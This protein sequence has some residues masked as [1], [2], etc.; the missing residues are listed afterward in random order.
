MNIAMPSF[1][2]APFH[3]AP[4]VVIDLPFPPSV[5]RLWR[6]GGDGASRVFL[7][8]SYVKWKDAADVLL[9]SSK[10]WRGKKICG[11]FSAEIAI[12]PPKGQARGDLDNRIKAVCD[13]L[14]RVE[15]IENDKHCQRLLIEWVDI[16]RA[17]TGCRVVV[18]ACA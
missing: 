15:I 2:D 10:G 5:N 3:V 4:D 11:A 1:S 18:R 16:S 8:K 13:F 9:L 17:P 12:S 14:Q 7:S 6:S